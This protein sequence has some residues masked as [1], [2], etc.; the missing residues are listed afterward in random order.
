MIVIKRQ[1]VEEIASHLLFCQKQFEDENV[2]ICPDFFSSDL[3]NLINNHLLNAPFTI[4]ADQ[5]KDGQLLS[6]EYT[7]SR[8]STLV[9]VLHFYLN[10]QTVIEAVKKISG[11][12]TINSFEGRVYKFEADQNSFDNWHDDMSD[13]RLLGMS[14]NLSTNAFDGGSFMIR[15]KK[16]KEV[17]AVVKHPN[18]GSAHFFRINNE[19]QH[20]VEK[21]EGEFPRIAFAGWFTDK[22]F[23]N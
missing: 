11:I 8:N 22:P 14:L 17:Y 4:K 21:V 10:Q 2:F 1:G 9:Q 20:K 19:L 7:I 6:Q 16:S 18:W 23:F 3:N 13:G 5:K 15:N 12:S